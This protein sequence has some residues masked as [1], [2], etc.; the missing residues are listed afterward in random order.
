[1]LN[2]G[3]IKTGSAWSGQKAAQYGVRWEHLTAKSTSK[4]DTELRGT[5]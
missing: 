1:M 3:V 5:Y 4:F 2:P